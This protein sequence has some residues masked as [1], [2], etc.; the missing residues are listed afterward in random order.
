MANSVL[1]NLQPGVGQEN[2]AQANESQRREDA[3]PP[4]RRQR[5]YH[6]VSSRDQICHSVTPPKSKTYLL[7]GNQYTSAALDHCSDH[8]F[9]SWTINICGPQVDKNQMLGSASFRS[10]KERTWNFS[11][12]TPH[13]ALELLNGCG[14]ILRVRLR[15]SPAGARC[16]RSLSFRV[17]YSLVILCNGLNLSGGSRV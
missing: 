17:H 8:I 15:T 10:G 4:F 13:M 2:P 6:H 12:G 11:Q 9:F 3:R 14:M 16:H 5:S 7:Q 1:V